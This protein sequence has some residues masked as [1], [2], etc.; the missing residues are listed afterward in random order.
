MP[1]YLH[2]DQS[3]YLGSSNQK[4]MKPWQKYVTQ[5]IAVIVYE[6]LLRSQGMLVFVHYNEQSIFTTP[7]FPIS[8]TIL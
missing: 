7:F 3:G 6:Q 5:I 8:V 1:P 2:L 4:Y